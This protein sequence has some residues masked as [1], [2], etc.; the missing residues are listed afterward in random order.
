MDDRSFLLIFGHH[1]LEE[2]L[3]VDNSIIIF[4]DLVYEGSDVCIGKRLILRLEALAQLISRNG[5]R[6]VL[7][8]VLEC[9]L[10]L[11]LLRVV[12]RVH[13]RCYELRV[14]NYSVVIRVYHAHR[15]LDIVDVQLY[16][17][18][19]L[20]TFQELLMSQLAVTVLVEFREGASQFC[21]LRLWNS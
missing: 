17:R 4:I 5:S 16:L 20:N 18:H 3:V 10:D 21:Y 9:L 19:R 8:E 1:H 12:L 11:L 14:I 7:V 6:V 15:L 13:A 2:L